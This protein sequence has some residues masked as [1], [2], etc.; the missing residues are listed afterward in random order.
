MAKYLSTPPEEVMKDY[1][2]Y[3]AFWEQHQSDEE[4]DRSAGLFVLIAGAISGF[5]IG[6]AFWLV[7]FWI[8]RR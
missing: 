2:K 8:M 5:I 6:T 7:Y 3:K 4:P 1:R